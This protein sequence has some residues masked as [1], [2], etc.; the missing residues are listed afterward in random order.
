ML[1]W[2]DEIELDEVGA[3][4]AAEENEEQLKQRFKIVDLDSLNWA[5]RKLSALEKSHTEES[6]LAKVEIN[7]IQAWFEKQDESYQY[8]KQFLEGLIKEYAREQRAI[9]PK[10]RSKTPYGLV[11]FRK[12]KKYDYGDEE[13]LVKFLEDNGMGEFVKVEKAPIK[14]ELKKA[15]TITKDGKAVLTS[16]GEV[17]PITVEET[18]NVTINLE[19]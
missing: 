5:L 2:L 17:L 14:K 12:A 4:F 11:S 9:T 18:E 10:W 8:S 13:K 16:T 3:M 6:R 1:N 15:L 7:R 19:G